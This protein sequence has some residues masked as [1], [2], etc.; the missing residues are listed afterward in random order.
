MVEIKWEKGYVVK[1]F[2]VDE[3][4]LSRF[5]MLIYFYFEVYLFK[6]IDKYWWFGVIYFGYFVF[7]IL[8]FDN[9]DMCR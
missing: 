1:C 2:N 9:Y 6:F 4:V 8:V 3:F 7:W 5:N